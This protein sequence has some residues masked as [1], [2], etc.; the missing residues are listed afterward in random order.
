MVRTK[1]TCS[2]SK[3][4]ALKILWERWYEILRQHQRG[5]IISTPLV[6]SKVHTSWQAF[7]SSQGPSSSNC[8]P[9]PDTIHED[10]CKALVS[11][12]SDSSSR[13]S[14]QI[15]E[16]SEQGEAENSDTYMDDK[17]EPVS[18]LD[19]WMTDTADKCVMT[20]TTK[21]L[22]HS[23]VMSVSKVHADNTVTTHTGPQ[24]LV[25]INQT[26]FTLEGWPMRHGR[27]CQTRDMMEVTACICSKPVEN[28]L[29]NA[30]TAVQCGYSGCETLWFHLECLNFEVPPR[31]WCCPNHIQP[32]KCQRC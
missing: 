17:R 30:D 31:N 13:T 12:D 3:N 26:E 5:N 32:T 10:N 19:H 4:A 15:D 18:T 7:L 27:I 8:A 23:R 6:I 1:P 14:H 22:E 2:E 20:D 16:E 9:T 28:E 24:Q 29:K 11:S 25:S 21:H